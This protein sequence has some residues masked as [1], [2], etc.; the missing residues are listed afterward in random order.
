MSL[1][2]NSWETERGLA[3]TLMQNEVWAVTMAF[4]TKGLFIAQVLTVVVVTVVVV[5]HYDTL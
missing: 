2:Q 4:S 1:N 5:I 3:V